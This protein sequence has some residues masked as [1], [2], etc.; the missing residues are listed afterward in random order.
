MSPVNVTLNDGYRAEAHARQFTL[1]LDEPSTSGGTDAG[2][3]P[4]EMLLSA[5]GACA[6]ITA[7]MYAA[8]KG[9]NL[10]SVDVSVDM[11]KFKAIDYPAY[12]GSADF[13]HEFRQMITFKGDLTQE[14]KERLLEI[15]GKCPIHR[16]LTSPNFVLDM[17]VD[18]TSGELHSVSSTVVVP[19]TASH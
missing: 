5:L 3:E 4:P 14:Q 2:P 12:Q 6:A 11:I 16:I 9:W 19:P 7:K 13:V 15:A 18:E 17:L 1:V 8:R 10:E